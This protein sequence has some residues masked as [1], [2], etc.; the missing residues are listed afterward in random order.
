[1][2]QERYLRMSLEEKRKLYKCGDHY[3]TLEDIPLWPC[4]YKVEAS[5]IHKMIRDFK[6]KHV[7]DRNF[8]FKQVYPKNLA[9]TLMY[10]S[11]S[12]NVRAGAIQ[13]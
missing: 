13:T 6:E 11:V 9:V 12:F 2:F 8:K 4:L 10:H 1:M 3:N 5:K 7:G